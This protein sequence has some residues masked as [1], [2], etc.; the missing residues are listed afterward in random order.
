M[1]RNDKYVVWHLCGPQGCGKTT[2]A[3]TA[4]QV[5]QAHGG[6]AM[7]LD[8][9]TFSCYFDGNPERVFDEVP[10]LTVLM[11]EDNTD[12]TGSG[13]YRPSHYMRG[14]KVIDLST[15]LTS[16][17]RRPE[18]GRVLVGTLLANPKWSGESAKWFAK[19]NYERLAPL[20]EAA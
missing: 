17:E 11:L 13:R 8:S 3:A 19:Q 16:I 14:D 20:P 1:N 4:R 15:Y 5:V 12:R 2:F 6:Y 9:H 18:I 10:Q 7:D